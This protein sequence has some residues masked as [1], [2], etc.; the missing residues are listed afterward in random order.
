M[1]LCFACTAPAVVFHNSSQKSS[2]QQLR[3][4]RELRA[5]PSLLLIQPK[6]SAERVQE[7]EYR[8]PLLLPAYRLRCHLR[9]TPTRPCC[10]LC[11]R[12]RHCW[13]IPRR[14]CPRR[15][16]CSHSGCCRHKHHAVPPHKH[17]PQLPPAVLLLP[18]PA[19]ALLAAAACR[20]AGAG[21]RGA[22]GCMHD[23]AEMAGSAAKSQQTVRATCLA[24]TQIGHRS[25]LPHLA[26]A[27]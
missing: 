6:G 21:W 16:C 14:G 23:L 25:Q 26:P 18:R 2:C 24:P 7:A 8:P 20:Q 12:R 11:C 27:A 10:C 1:L 19:H 9:L 4:L 22:C 3:A 17:L 5:A 15:S 13:R